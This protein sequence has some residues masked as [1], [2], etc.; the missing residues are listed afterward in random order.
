MV[1][2]SARVSG[3]QGGHRINQGAWGAKGDLWHK[4]VRRLRGEDVRRNKRAREARGVWGDMAGHV[5]GD[6]GVRETKESSRER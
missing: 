3:R 6:K 2:V 1:R 4:V 5:K